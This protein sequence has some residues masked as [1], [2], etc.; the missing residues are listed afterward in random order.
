MNA[1]LVDRSHVLN[2]HATESVAGTVLTRT[3]RTADFSWGTLALTLPGG[4]YRLCW[5]AGGGPRV[6]GDSGLN[7]TM[8]YNSSEPCCGQLFHAPGDAAAAYRCPASAPQCVGYGPG[9][10][11]FPNGY[12]AGYGPG[13]NAFA[14]VTYGRCYSYFDH[15]CVTAGEFVVDLGEFTVVGPEVRK[16]HFLKAPLSACTNHSMLRSVI[17]KLENA[18]QGSRCLLHQ[19]TRPTI[20]EHDSACVQC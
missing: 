16:E 13:P 15:G 12:G 1:T 14:N 17:S 19:R 5:C 2:E 8:D 18:A 6:T 9:P 11:V 20:F 7:C 3:S 4:T 10:A